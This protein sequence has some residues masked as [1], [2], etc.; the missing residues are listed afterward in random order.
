MT[1]LRAACEQ[2]K[3]VSRGVRGDGRRLP[4]CPFSEAVTIATVPP[5]FRG[6]SRQRSQWMVVYLEASAQTKRTLPHSDCASVFQHPQR[7]S[8][9]TPKK[10]LQQGYPRPF[11]LPERFKE[12]GWGRR[13]SAFGGCCG[14][15]YQKVGTAFKTQQHAHEERFCRS[16]VRTASSF[17]PVSN[18]GKD[19]LTTMNRLPTKLATTTGG[20]AH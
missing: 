9:T 13:S 10:G 18:D 6:C 20:L 11:P 16:P 7:G 15:I 14:T 3:V 19:N 4:R 5:G 2:G 8:A 17:F 12:L 1:Q